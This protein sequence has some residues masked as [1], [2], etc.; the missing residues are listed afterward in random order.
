MFIASWLSGQGTFILDGNVEDSA[1]A[2]IS[3]FQ[4]WQWI[5]HSQQI[6]GKNRENVIDLPMVQAMAE[7]IVK[8]E[9]EHPQKSLALELFLELIQT[10]TQFITTWLNQNSSFRQISLQSAQ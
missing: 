8:K 1:T 6:D 4:V 2:E 10:Q 7:E 3:R 5:H 9:L